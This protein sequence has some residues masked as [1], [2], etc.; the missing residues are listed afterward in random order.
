VRRALDCRFHLRSGE[1]TNADHADIAIRPGLLGGPLDEV[2]HVPAFLAVE[3]PKSA[4]G[5]AGASAIC[6]HVHIA[7]R[8]EEVAG[9]SFDEAGRRA[10]I[11]NLPRIRR[12]C[13]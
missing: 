12:C 5:T 4:T 10:E 2:V 7:A 8:N 3:K 6:D 1:V 9:A 13:N 11:L